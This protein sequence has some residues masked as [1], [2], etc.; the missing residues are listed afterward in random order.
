MFSPQANR[1]FRHASGYGHDLFTGYVAHN[2]LTHMQDILDL[3][4]QVDQRK[5][6]ES[7]VF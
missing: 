2:N 4:D 3:E 6:I 7:H 1:A 5:G